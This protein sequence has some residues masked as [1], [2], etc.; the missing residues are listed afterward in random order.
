MLWARGSLQQMISWKSQSV[1][2]QQ[3]IYSYY[4]YLII[5]I[6][7]GYR[8]RVYTQHS[9]ISCCCDVLLSAGK[10]C[11]LWHVPVFQNRKTYIYSKLQFQTIRGSKRERPVLIRGWGQN[12]AIFLWP[13]NRCIACI[14][15]SWTTIITFFWERL[16]HVPETFDFRGAVR[17]FCCLIYQVYNTRVYQYVQ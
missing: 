14:S 16:S 4:T 12:K 8:S 1:L 15:I 11:S 2:L 3:Y 9:Y 10:H 13:D 17:V 5:I 6:V 7:A